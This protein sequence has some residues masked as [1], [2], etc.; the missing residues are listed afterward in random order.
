MKKSVRKFAAN[1][2]QG[3]FEI[4]SLLL[5]LK[6]QVVS[7]DQ[8]LWQYQ[9][10]FSCGPD[11]CYPPGQNYQLRVLVRYTRIAGF[12]VAVPTGVQECVQTC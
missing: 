10:C 5:P 3:T 12:P 8:Y 4:L 7:A 1:L 6:E 9:P 11:V 2:K